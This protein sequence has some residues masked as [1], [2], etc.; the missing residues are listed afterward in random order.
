MPPEVL[1]GQGDQDTLGYLDEVCCV[2]EV[3][4]WGDNRGSTVIKKIW[5]KG[6]QKALQLWATGSKTRT[7]KKNNPSLEGTAEMPIKK[8]DAHSQHPGA[9]VT[10][11]LPPT[12]TLR[13][14]FL[15]R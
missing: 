12:S 5:E 13:V 2:T 1:Y 15:S 7:H 4:E 8:R 10:P 6:D 11:G 14:S 9:V 3:T